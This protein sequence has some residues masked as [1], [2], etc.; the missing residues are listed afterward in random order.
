MA[1]KV[2]YEFLFVGRDENSYLENFT[3]DLFEDYGDEGGQLFANLEIANN[4]LDAEEI[5][6]RF[7]EALQTEFYK[8][9]GV[10]TPYERFE[11]A[12]KGANAVFNR[13]RQSKPSRFIGDL[14]IVVSA[15]VGKNL[16]LSQCGEAEAYLVRKKFVSV[17]TEGLNDGIDKDG[18]VFVNIA[19][20]A[21]EP[22]DFVL[23]STTRLLRYVSKTDLAN[24][25][26]RDNVAET[27]A[28]LRDI[29]SPEILGRIGFTGILFKE[30]TVG[31]AAMHQEQ[32]FEEKETV[33]SRKVDGG[34]QYVRSR[35]RR[36]LS[37]GAGITGKIWDKLRG[38]KEKAKSKY[39][40]V[41]KRFDG[42]RIVEDRGA[43]SRSFAKPMYKRK[44][45]FMLL[46]VIVLLMVGIYVT[47]VRSDKQVE[48]DRLSTVLSNVQSKLFEAEN[49]A[50]YDKQT[51]VTI[52]D[53]AYDDALSVLKSGYFRAKSQEYLL[54][55]ETSRD[56]LDNVKR[57]TKPDAFIDLALKN[58]VIN[59]IGFVT[60]KNKVFA[61]DE[62]SLYEIVLDQVQAPIN[63]DEKET[64][65][66]ATGFDERGSVVAL[67]KSGKMIEYKDGAISFIDTADGSF[68]KGVSLEDWSNKIYMLDAASNQIWKYPYKSSKN[69]FDKAEPYLADNSV[70]DMSTASDF[71][72]DSN[73]YVLTDAMNILKLYGGKASQNFSITNPPFKSYIAPNVI[74]TGEKIDY[75]F[76]MDPE[77]GRVYIF[78]KGTPSTASTSG[79]GGNLVYDSQLYFEDLKDMRDL[80]YDQNSGKVYILTASK[81]YEASIK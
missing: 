25:L 66:T 27:M 58:P 69:Q 31:E 80:Y 4:P 67:T 76:V 2:K 74:Y 56:K 6:A 38:Y 23:Y 35:T 21:V 8:E 61:Y 46:A 19:T 24:C 22:S 30:E 7:F 36:S 43:S 55:I 32:V 44:Y 41:S 51:A 73:V 54:K 12:L 18:D 42:K 20:G 3:Y 28:E 71:S 13:F 47:K 53:S 37:I 39:D 60:V 78:R 79:N 5:S 81:I 70:V 49:K 29:I 65:L 17:V 1:L 48:I 15:L 57:I 26:F 34:D 11:A 77:S 72:I 63:L 52:L 45:L 14:N 9:V 50:I 40:T 33:S 68:H 16:Y 75:V 64:I 10:K 62:K 59:A